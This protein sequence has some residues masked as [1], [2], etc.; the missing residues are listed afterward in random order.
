MEPPKETFDA[1][2]LD[3]LAALG[4]TVLQLGLYGAEHPTVLETLKSAEDLIGSALAS[5]PQGSLTFAKDQDKWLVNGRIVGLVKQVGGPVSILI[6]R[7]KLS[8][9]TLKSGLTS[10]DLIA[11]CELSALGHDSGA[12]A[13]TFLAERSAV[14]VVLNEAVYAEVGPDGKPAF[15]PGEGEGGGDGGDAPAAAKEAGLRQQIEGQTLETSI[16]VLVKKVARSPA[17]EAL[18]FRLIM[19][20]LR[21]DIEK[22]VTQA[23][24]VLRQEK[25]VVEF[26]RARTENILDNVGAG[27]I[28][29]DE[30]GNILMMNPAAEE[31]YGA[32][33]A[34]VAGK[35]ISAKSD[36]KHVVALAAE[37]E[38]SIDKPLSKDVEVRG[39]DDTKRLIRS[40]WAVVKNEAGRVVGMVL[41]LT[42]LAAHKKVEKMEQEFVAHMTHE[43]RSPLASISAGLDL[44]MRSYKGKI[45]EQQSTL[46][47]A[48]SSN[49]NR[50][51]SLVN[52]ILDF[53]KI[54]SGQMTVYP[55][56]A[57]AGKIGALAVDSL[58]PWAA[59]KELGLSL[60]AA[61]GLPQVFAD[62]ERTVQVLVNLISN[63]LKFTPKGGRILVTVAALPHEA[64]RFVTFA[65]R[66]NGCG[67][68]LAD[69]ARVFEKFAQVNNPAN[70]GGTGLGL[71]IA[72]SMVELQGGRMWLE[73]EEGKGSVFYFTLPVYTPEAAAAPPPEPERPWWKRL[74]GLS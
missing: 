20:Q 48:C 18:L 38:A 57:E 9:V 61:P 71:P 55:K 49:V 51:G 67:I 39:A 24:Q 44:L 12:D 62:S 56:P 30:G 5:S 28:V 8:S 2:C 11:I 50:L 33:L 47:A 41:A 34:E 7:H 54:E 45:D 72:K 21:R 74:L 36:P 29:I 10:K 42:D 23:T 53:S 59:K 37:I 27:A 6:D 14:N 15:K 60:S 66:D 43:L 73:S 13:Q 31:I 68:P 25:G 63:A 69:R 32:K 26:E 35:P 1:Q 16:Q 40:S 58:L 52:N 70:V 17:E 65:V 19:E 64:D 46:F 3:A 4:K 22:S